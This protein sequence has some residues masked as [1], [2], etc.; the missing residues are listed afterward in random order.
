MSGQERPEVHR[1]PSQV[2]ADAFHP[3]ALVDGREG[4]WLSA[5]FSEMKQ[6]AITLVGVQQVIDEQRVPIL[7]MANVP[8]EWVVTEL[9]D[10]FDRD[11]PFIFPPLLL[12]V[13][14][15]QPPSVLGDEVVASCWIWTR[16]CWR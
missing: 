13:S 15:C 9:L 3:G 14:V 16:G 1:H 5:C 7:V 6:L 10:N 8:I 11:G 2:S 4:D 12:V